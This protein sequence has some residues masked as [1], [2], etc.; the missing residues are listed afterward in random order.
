MD[1]LYLETG[2][3]VIK[4]F[5]CGCLAVS[6]QGAQ[7][8]PLL[9]SCHFPRGNTAKF[10]ICSKSKEGPT[11][12][13]KLIQPFCINKFEQ[14]WWT[15]SKHYYVHYL[16]GSEFFR[17]LLQYM[18][19]IFFQINFFGHIQSFSRCVCHRESVLAQAWTSHHQVLRIVSY[20]F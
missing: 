14:F 3:Q 6:S 10:H 13:P 20:D 1:T 2:M 12:H 17:C 7:R 19:K 4:Q 18:F 15:F 11:N 5:R 16:K 9:V 8:S